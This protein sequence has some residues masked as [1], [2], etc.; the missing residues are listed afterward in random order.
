MK[1]VGINVER[2]IAAFAWNQDGLFIICAISG[3]IRP[4]RSV[5]PSIGDRAHRL[6]ISVR[7]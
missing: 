2:L 7:S 3:V 4:L 1:R 6:L 5:I